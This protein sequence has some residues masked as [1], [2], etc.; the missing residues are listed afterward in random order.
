MAE[1]APKF[2]LHRNTISP[3]WKKRKISVETNTPMDLHP[4]YAGNTGPHNQ[5]ILPQSIL[6]IPV[7]LR[8]TYRDLGHALQKS[9]STIHRHMKQGEI[10][11]HSNPLKP[12]LTEANKRARLMYCISKI[13][14]GTL[15]T[16]PTYIPME[17]IVHIDEKWF[18]LTRKNH[19]MLL[20]PK[21]KN[22]HRTARSKNFIPKIMFMS[23]VMRPRWN[24]D[25]SCKNS[26]K[27][28]IWPF[29]Y[30]YV[31]KK[32]SVNRKRGT[33]E[34][35]PVESVNKPEF[36]KMMSKHVIPA[37]KA[38]WPT[39]LP[40]IVHIQADNAKPHGGADINE[41]IQNHGDH[42][43]TFY[44]NPQPPNSPDLNILDLGFF[45]SIQ[46][47]Y[48]KTMPKNID[49]LIEEVKQAFEDLHPKTLSNVWMSLQYCMN[50]IM[51]CNGNCDY[52]Q[53]HMKK[54]QLEDEGTLPWQV[55][56]EVQV[57]QN[58]ITFLTNPEN[59][60]REAIIELAAV[61]EAAQAGEE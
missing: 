57:V 46:S 21:E 30:Q 35:R 26:G 15:Q 44:W 23:A 24:Q 3:L 54:K 2:G 48:E 13:I 47:K 41:F 17:N 43:W 29:S 4:K 58:A 9:A 49:K 1:A 31:A 40:K 33:L 5:P 38:N 39:D 12:G 53:P 19:H 59:V 42:E 14:P 37:I 61:Q 20:A 55:Q 34:T 11:P 28:G 56:P 51:R 8:T 60:M 32:N 27:L 18:Y 22:P 50:E 45:R 36:R 6:G 16:N 25:G 10:R 7:G 52:V